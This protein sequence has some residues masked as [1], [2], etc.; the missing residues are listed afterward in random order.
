M[1]FIRKY[2]FKILKWIIFA[3]SV[4]FLADR[5]IFHQEYREVFSNLNFNKGL[6]LLY[7]LIAFCLMF[8]NWGLEAVKWKYAIS[9]IRKISFLK[10]YAAVLAGTSVSLFMPNRTGEFV[11]RIFAL[12]RNE[13]VKAVFAS[14][15][16]SFS[17][18]IVTI[19]AGTIALFVFYFL[20]PDNTLVEKGI[21]VWLKYFAIF[22][23]IISIIVFFKINWFTYFFEKWSFLKKY[24]KTAQILNSFN[25]AVLFNFLILSLLRYTVFVLQFYFLIKFF[26]IDLSLWTCVIS[27]SLTF[28]VVTIIPTFTLA[29]IGIRGSVAVIFFGFFTNMY[30]EI[31]SASTLL[32]IIN[33]GIPALIGNVFVAGFKESEKNNY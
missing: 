18:L 1:D 6:N 2:G 12:P 15:A 13:R 5:I 32:W 30:A 33:V 10:A 3:G 23:A 17:Q 11:G 31:I 8:L 25:S 4:L 28:Y 14:I 29:E 26:G 27:S 7:F 22:I 19:I 20:F 16:S 9:G 24:S 21:N